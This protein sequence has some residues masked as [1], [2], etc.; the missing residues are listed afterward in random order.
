[1]NEENKK[2]LEEADKTLDLALKKVA[3]YV[4]VE[5]RVPTPGGGNVL[6]T[7]TSILVAAKAIVA[8]LKELE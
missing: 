5:H 7:A 1:M 4:P 3:A 8:A 6:T 2:V